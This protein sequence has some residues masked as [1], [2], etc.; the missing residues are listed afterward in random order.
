MDSRVITLSDPQRGTNRRQ[1]GKRLG[2]PMVWVALGLTACGGA[3]PTQPTGTGSTDA[4]SA[5]YDRAAYCSTW[6]GLQSDAD[7]MESP[8]L[9][10]GMV[11]RLAA[12]APPELTDDVGLWVDSGDRTVPLHEE[13]G[14]EVSSERRAEIERELA[15][16]EQPLKDAF[17][18][19]VTHGQSTC[20]G[21]FGLTD[22]RRGTELAATRLASKI[23]ARIVEVPPTDQAAADATTLCLVLDGVTMEPCLTVSN[24]P[25]SQPQLTNM[26]NGP[27]PWHADQPIGTLVTLGVQLPPGS[28]RIAGVHDQRGTA[29]FMAQSTDGTLI[30]AAVLDPPEASAR[31][32]EPIDLIGPDGTVVFPNVTWPGPMVMTLPPDT[33][34]PSTTA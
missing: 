32:E 14:R 25:P 5:G 31:R 22:W 17:V 9:Q 8:E 12:T 10:L 30:L 34:S 23:E 11:L 7:P 28:P 6:A 3:N 1:R 26:S 33:R 24:R 27:F 21:A 19:I 29:L 20:P 15:A 16:L 2:R 4:A 13:L 18:R